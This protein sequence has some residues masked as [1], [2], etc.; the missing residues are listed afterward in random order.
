MFNEYYY[1]DLYQEPIYVS[2]LTLNNSVETTLYIGSKL[3]RR[4][5]LQ[6]GLHVLEKDD[7][8][9]KLKIKWFEAIPELTIADEKV[10]LKKIKRKDLREIL[11]TLGIN[12]ALNPKEK[13][14]KAFDIKKLR[15]PFFLIVAGTIW[16]V[17]TQDMGQLWNVPS[18]LIFT[19]AY[20]IV[21]SPLI[22]K[23]PERH[24]DTDTKGKFKFILGIGAMIFTQIIIDK[25][26]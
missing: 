21:F 3:A 25:L 18:M 19:I 16:E 9:L 22:D 26:V 7:V 6:R 8:K 10:E 24:M 20:V 14:K 2:I 1:T 23:V 17:L 5:S 13:P 15:G 4:Q 12:N 11:I